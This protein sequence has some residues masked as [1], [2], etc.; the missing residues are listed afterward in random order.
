EQ[1]VNGLRLNF[2]TEQ[3]TTQTLHTVGY[4]LEWTGTTITESRNSLQ[5]NLDTG[6]STSI[7]L[8]EQFPLRDFPIS[9]VNEIGLYINDEI[10]I[11]DSNWSIIPALRYDYYDLEPKPDPVYLGGSPDS[12]I[13]S[14]TEGSLSPKLGAVYEL[15]DSSQMFVQYIHGFR[16]PPFA[17]ANIGLDIPMFNMR[18]IPNPDLKSETSDGFEIGYNV[19]NHSHQFDVAGFYNDYKDFIQSKVNL[20]FDPVSGLILFQSQNINSAEI[21]G[22]E[23]SYEYGLEDWIAQSDYLTA[24]VNFFYSKGTNKETSEPLNSIEPSQ[25]VIGLVWTSPSQDWSIGFH[26]TLVDGKDDLDES[27]EELFKPAGYAVYDLIA[28]Y[29]VSEDV[30]LSLAINNLSDHKYWRWS[31]VNGLVVGDPILESLSAPGIN[32]SLQLKIQW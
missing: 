7:I 3:T 21:Y 23:A 5:T 29:E 9:D 6:T 22:V 2:Y 26:T 12:N 8:S 10:S 24:S 13:V 1:E 30:S 27:Q 16:A 17:D 25:A 20:G 11:T 19:S 32:G 15:S 4:G 31:D 28:N 18:A 14:I